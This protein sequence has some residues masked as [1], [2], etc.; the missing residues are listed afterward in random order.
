VKVE[1]DVLPHINGSARVVIADV[2]EVLCSIKLDVA[3]LAPGSPHKGKLEVAADFSPS[4]NLKL[5][6]RRLNDVGAHLAQQLQRVLIGSLESVLTSLCIIPDRFCWRLHIDLL[7]TKLD[8]DPLDACSMAICAA[9]KCTK[10]PRVELVRGPSGLAVD[11]EVV[12]D[13]SSALAFPADEVP[14]CTTFVKVGNTLVVD[15][16]SSEHACA[17]SALT[18]AMN[19]HGQCCGMFKLGGGGAL[20]ET[21]VLK[22]LSD[23]QALLP[24]TFNHI[25]KSGGG[26]GGGSGSATKIVGLGADGEQRISRR[27]GLIT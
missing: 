25:D 7:V 21:E 16:S 11:F 2:I 26:G 19:R 13:P 17:S 14:L 22:V 24:S 4:C 15:A 1:L 10:V 27:A 9:L 8:G 3:E 12:G 23:A 6:E 20:T 5:D 18:V